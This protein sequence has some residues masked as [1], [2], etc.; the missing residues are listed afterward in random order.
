MGLIDRLPTIPQEVND[1]IAQVMVAAKANNVPIGISL[2]SKIE[3]GQKFLDSG[4][5]ILILGQEIDYL[6]KIRN[7]VEKLKST[8][9]I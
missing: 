2:G 9:E 7:D 1:A 5:R 4:V 6:K 3:D 8:L